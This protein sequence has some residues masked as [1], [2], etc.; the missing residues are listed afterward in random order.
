MLQG[1][2][3]PEIWTSVFAVQAA[4]ACGLVWRLE[5]EGLV[6]TAMVVVV[7]P[8]AVFESLALGLSMD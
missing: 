7:E 6:G 1:V 8:D 2:A 4:V 3:P 5:V